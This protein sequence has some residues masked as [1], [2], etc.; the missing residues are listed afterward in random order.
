MEKQIVGGIKIPHPTFTFPS[1]QPPLKLK[2]FS[3]L[4]TYHPGLGYLFD[5]SGD[6]TI[7]IQLDSLFRTKHAEHSVQEPKIVHLE[8]ENRS[9]KDEFESR[10]AYMKVTHLL[11]PI[12][13][14]RGK[15]GFEE[16]GSP[17]FFNPSTLPSRA[18][19]KITD[20]MNQAYVEA[21]ASYALSKL[22]EADV[23]PHFHYF[24]GAYCGIADAYSYNI[25]DVYSTYRHCRWFWENQTK[26]IFQ[27]EVDNE[28]MDPEVKSAIFEPPSELHSEVSSEVSEEDLEDE[29]EELEPSEELQKVELQSLHSTAMSSVSFKTQSEETDEADENEKEEENESDDLD[30]EDEDEEINVLA[31]LKKFPVMLLFTE[32]S[33]GTMDDL[34]TGWDGEGEE[35]V[36]GDKEWEEIWTAWLFQILAALSVLQTFFGFT[37]NDLHTNNIV[38]THTDQKYFF[39]Q[40]RDGTV[41]RIPTYG[42]VFRLIDFG[43]SIFWINEKLFFS[44]DFKEGNDAAEQFSFGPLR[45]DESQEEVYPNPS[46]D[47]CRLA[48]SL[49]EALFPMKP[50]PKKGGVVLSSEPGLVVR[51]SKSHLY[52][53]LWSWMVDDDGRNVLMEPN[54][55]ERYP[56]FDLYKVI[57]QKVHNAVPRVQILRPIFDRYKVGKQS[58]GKKQKVYNLFF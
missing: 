13:W 52:N 10:S 16:E 35:A 11:D 4:H 40:N 50:E 55:R 8:L 56:D 58:V 34:L 42:K 14:I 37:H 5:V 20:P 23:S 36:P 22:R 53:L 24:Y 2:S 17:D 44:D 3:N 21:V 29:C 28:D 47:L 31:R 25:S 32:P 26:N 48:V 1:R 43:R 45:T 39:Y 54:G 46:F 12:T 9:A 6:S 33:Q 57:T 49:F 7:P 18:R 41:W 15:Y 27:L 30:F 19:E 38:W 51:E